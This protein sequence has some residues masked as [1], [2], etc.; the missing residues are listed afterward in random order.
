MKTK[1]QLYD[2]SNEA[3]KK[4]FETNWK[5]CRSM[6][7]TFE[8]DKHSHYGNTTNNRLES[9]NQKLK[10]LTTRSSSLSEMFQNLLL[11]S[12]TAAAEYSQCAFQEEFTVRLGVHNI[13]EASEI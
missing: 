5:E 10:D 8:R 2:A 3:F 11:Y 7:V 13:P 4:Y 12:H 1:K 9:H 6:W